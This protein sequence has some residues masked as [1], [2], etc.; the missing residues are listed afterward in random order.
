MKTTKLFFIALL[1]CA[2]S[3][4]AMAQIEKGKN[5]V[6]GYASYHINDRGLTTTDYYIGPR[7]GR[8]ISKDFE[9]GISIGYS[10]SIKEYA[11]SAKTTTR[12]FFGGPYV[13]LYRNLSEHFYFDASLILGY[14]SG[15]IVYDDTQGVNIIGQNTNIDVTVLSAKVAPALTYLFNNHWAAEFSVGIFN[16]TNTRTKYNNSSSPSLVGDFTMGIFAPESGIG[17]EYYF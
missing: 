16:Y 6:G 9:I 12:T 8:L 3:S 2:I 1:L 13:K 5:V 14:S 4:A 17:I 15:K 11:A 10:A 7:Y